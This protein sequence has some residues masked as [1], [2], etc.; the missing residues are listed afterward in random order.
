MKDKTSRY[1]IRLKHALFLLLFIILIAGIRTWQQRG[2]ASSIAPPLQGILLSGTPYSLPAKPGQ[3]V[4]V[5]FWA[6]WCQPCRAEQGSIAAI[7]QD[8]PNTITVAIRSGNDA[9]VTGHLAEQGLHF[10]VLNDADGRISSAWGVQAVPASFIIGP[11]GQIRFAEVGYQS[12]FELR[13]RLWLA[14]MMV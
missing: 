4:L 14:G 6:T 3:P 2:A 11:E 10:A 9:I 1:K 12:E 13:I 7:S 5:N 8:R